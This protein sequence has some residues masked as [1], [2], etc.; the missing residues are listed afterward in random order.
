M[1]PRVFQ[2][3]GPVMLTEK[4]TVAVDRHFFFIMLISSVYQNNV[5][6]F[7][8]TNM[9]LIMKSYSHTQGVHMFRCQPESTVGRCVV[10]Y[11]NLTPRHFMRS[12]LNFIPAARNKVVN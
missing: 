11:E 2:A 1:G 10:A 3:S 12:I 7:I 4:R 8:D 6:L 5:S 9:S